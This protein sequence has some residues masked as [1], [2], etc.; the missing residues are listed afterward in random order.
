MFASVLLLPTAAPQAAR[1]CGRDMTA[2]TKCYFETE[3][4][5]RAAMHGEGGTCVPAQD[6]S[7]RADAP[8]PTARA[9]RPPRKPQTRFGQ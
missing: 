8:P 9:R 4:Q 1:W 2:E 6:A 3:G 5:C 7:P